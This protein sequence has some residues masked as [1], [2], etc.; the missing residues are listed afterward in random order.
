MFNFMFRGGL[1]QG[2]NLKENYNMFIEKGIILYCYKHC[3]GTCLK[4]QKYNLSYVGA[5]IVHQIA[6]KQNDFP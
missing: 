4:A 2:Y 6:Q 5:D 3:R 1:G